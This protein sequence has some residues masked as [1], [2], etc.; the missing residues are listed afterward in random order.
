VTTKANEISVNGV[1]FAEER[2][3]GAERGMHMGKRA[4]AVLLLAFLLLALA[5]AVSAN[6]A[7]PPGLTVLVLSP[8]EDLTL[9]IRFAGRDEQT[10]IELD[11]RSRAW[12]GYY[13]F[14]YHMDPEAREA[15][16]QGAELVA[17][18][19]GEQFVCQL[20]EA[21]LGGYNNQVTLD[22]ENRRVMT[23][24]P[25]WRTPLLVLLRVALTLL[26]EG[27]VFFAFGYRSGRSWALFAAVNL[28]TQG[29][30]NALFIGPN[31]GSYALFGYALG[32]IAVFAVEAAAFALLLRERGRGRAVACALAANLVSLVAGGLMLTYLPI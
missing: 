23:G 12:E 1:S 13:R 22:L 15:V 2:T 14:F 16:E 17:T 28:V 32:E 30:L 7:E 9:S 31:V 25:A 21:A 27:A 18:A 19:G 10:G 3:G 26:M 5:P 4:A 6:A 8:P 20:P 29:A 11:K 24:Q